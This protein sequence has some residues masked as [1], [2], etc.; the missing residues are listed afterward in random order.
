M[1]Y[2]VIGSRILGD[3]RLEESDL[4]EYN[5]TGNLIISGHKV[6]EDYFKISGIDFGDYGDTPELAEIIR[7]STGQGA[8][9]RIWEDGDLEFI[10]VDQGTLNTQSWFMEWLEPKVLQEFF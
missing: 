8:I 9:L 1:S 2:N 4:D 10:K 6:A 7:K 5:L 3:I